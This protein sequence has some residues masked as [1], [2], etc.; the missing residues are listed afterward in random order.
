MFREEAVGLEALRTTNTLRVPRV[1][2]VG[3]VHDGRRVED[4][5]VLEQLNSSVQPPDFFDAFG[6]RLA[7]MHRV[8]SDQA[9]W[10][11]DNFLG[12]TPQRNTRSSSWIHFFREERLEY[13]LQL[14]TQNNF[15]D[16]KLTHSVSKLCERLDHLLDTTDTLGLLHGDLWNGNYLCDEFG[17]PA[18]FDPAVYFGHRE[19][20]LAMPVL[21]GGFPDRFFRSYNEAWPMQDG[22]QDRVEIYKLYHLLN[23]LNLF[24][25]SYLSQCIE[26]ASRF[27]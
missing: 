25:R 16:S 3:Q 27:I 10:D 13:Q 5:L 9:G 20:E 15:A 22:W 26:V 21:F 7:A 11:S 19:A 18:V 4:C 12:A 8:V 1:L 14:A 24:G 2:A 23:H 17:Q 6:T